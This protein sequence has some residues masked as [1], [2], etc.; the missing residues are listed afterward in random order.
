[1]ARFFYRCH[2][3]SVAH[4]AAYFHKKNNAIFDAFGLTDI[5][6][7]DILTIHDDYRGPG[8]GV[9]LDGEVG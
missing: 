3:I 2:G 6:S 1:M 9:P 4:D 8:Y 5:R 7:E